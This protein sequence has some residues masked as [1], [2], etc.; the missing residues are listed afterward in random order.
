MLHEAGAPAAEVRAYLERWALVTPELSAHLLR[1]LGDPSSRGYE[2]TYPAGLELC[3][4]YVG[5]GGD[6]FRRLLHEQVRVGDL[7]AAREA[8][9]DRP[10]AV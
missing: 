1:F 4:A 6:R 2:V 7:L 9:A 10:P 5:G 3:R 8:G